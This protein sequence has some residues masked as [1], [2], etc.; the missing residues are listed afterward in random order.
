MLSISVMKGA[1]HQG[2]V[3]RLPIKHEA[4]KVSANESKPARPAP[5]KSIGVNAQAISE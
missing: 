3:K 4:A 5:P 2:G 1:M